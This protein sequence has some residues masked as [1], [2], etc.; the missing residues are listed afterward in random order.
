MTMCTGTS[1]HFIS[2]SVF[3]IR[4]PPPPNKPWL[5]ENAEKVVVS[6]ATAVLIAAVLAWLG[7][8]K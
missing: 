6:V 3:Y 5:L 4:P 7:L 8:G 1:R 2:T